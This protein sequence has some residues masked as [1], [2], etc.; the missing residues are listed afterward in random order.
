MSPLSVCSEGMGHVAVGTG[1][2]VPQQPVPC[3]AKIQAVEW[4]RASIQNK[5]DTSGRRHVLD[6]F[7][8][9]HST[10]VGWAVAGPSNDGL[11]AG[12]VPGAFRRSIG[13]KGVTRPTLGT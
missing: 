4:T 8:S 3:I 5:A 2:L 1:S 9:V 7:Q 13:A 12:T 11:A 6:G 10:R